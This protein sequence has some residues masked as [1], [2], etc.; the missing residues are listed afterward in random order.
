MDPFIFRE[1]SSEFDYN[2]S[3][4]QLK[5]H[6]LRIA[7]MYPDSLIEVRSEINI[8]LNKLIDETSAKPE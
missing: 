6:I 8:L 5:M 3:L 7:N 2:I 4:C 1:L